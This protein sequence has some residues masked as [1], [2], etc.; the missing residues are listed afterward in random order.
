MQLPISHSQIAID[1]HE[2]NEAEHRNTRRDRIT[3]AIDPLKTFVLNI[4]VAVFKLNLNFVKH[5]RRDLKS[6]VLVSKSD[7]CFLQC[8]LKIQSGMWF[9]IIDFKR[10]RLFV[11]RYVLRLI[12]LADK[13]QRP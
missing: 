3:T 10:A 12:L 4:L 5:W 9:R 6:I 11:S 1:D 2:C 7:N 8:F 13:E